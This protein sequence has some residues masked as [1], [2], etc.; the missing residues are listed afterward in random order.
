MCELTGLTGGEDFGIWV[1][2][3]VI[4]WEWGSVILIL[5]AD[6]SLVKRATQGL[7]VLLRENCKYSCNTSPM[8]PT[9]RHVGYTQ[10]HTLT[11]A[12]ISRLLCQN[13][14]G[15]ASKSINYLNTYNHN[16]TTAPAF[17]SAHP[18]THAHPISDHINYNYYALF[19]TAFSTISFPSNSCDLISPLIIK[20][21]L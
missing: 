4:V 13:T 14:H 11:R 2:Q 1:Q 21:R 6:Q 17:S 16:Q 9:R 20:Y 18:R 12:H 10:T 3:A 7:Y 8:F 5:V 15:C 19:K